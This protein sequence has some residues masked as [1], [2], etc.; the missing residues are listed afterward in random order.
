MEYLFAMRSKPKQCKWGSIAFLLSLFLVPANTSIAAPGDL[1]LEIIATNEDANIGPDFNSITQFIVSP[2]ADIAPVAIDDSGFISFSADVETADGFERGFFQ[3]FAPGVFSTIL[4]TDQL[5]PGMTQADQSEP[6][7]FRFLELDQGRGFAVSP[8]GQSHAITVFTR[9]DGPFLY[10]ADGGTVDDTPTT[11]P[12]LLSPTRNFWEAVDISDGRGTTKM[13]S[14]GT[15]SNMLVSDTGAI[16]WQRGSAILR[17]FLPG[18]ISAVMFLDTPAPGFDESENA[19]LGAP[20]NFIGIDGSENAVFFCK[21]NKASGNENA[22]YRQNSSD[23]S[24]TLL[25]VEGVDSLPGGPGLEGLSAQ[26]QEEDIWV[27]Q[28]GAIYLRGRVS[29][30]LGGFW[31]ITIDAEGTMATELLGLFSSNGFSPAVTDLGEVDFRNIHL[32]DW[33]VSE[34]GTVF[35]SADVAGSEGEATSAMEGV[36]MIDPTDLSVKTVAR[37]G[38]NADPGSTDATYKIFSDITAAG[39]DKVAFIAELSDGNRGLFATDINGGVIKIALEGSP[40]ISCEDPEDTELEC[41]VIDSIHFTPDHAGEDLVISKGSPGLNKFGELAFLAT[42]ENGK[43]ALVRAKFE[44][45]ERPIGTTFIWDGGAGTNDWHTITDGRSN[46]TDIA[47]TPWNK[48]PGTQGNE[49]VFV[50]TGA[51][52]ELR[53][54]VSIRELTLDVSVLSLFAD[55]EFSHFLNGAGGSVLDL[56]LGKIVSTGG[57]FI[58]SGS[59]IKKGTDA[60][61]VEVDDFELTGGSVTVK[62]GTLNFK[63]TISNF[64]DSA[65]LVEDGLF[66]FDENVTA[67]RGDGTT[68]TVKMGTLDLDVFALSFEDNV[69]LVAE[70]SG[71]MI[72]IGR[73][74]MVE[75]ASIKLRSGGSTSARTFTLSGGGSFELRKD[76]DLI[77]GDR[78]INNHSGIEGTGLIIDID[79]DDALTVP[80]EVSFINQGRLVLKDGGLTYGSQPNES[81]KILNR[82]ILLV[83]SEGSIIRFDCSSEAGG[84]MIL[85]G[86]AAFGS[87]EFS[88]ITKLRTVGGTLVPLDGNS[89]S[90]FDKDS[91]IIGESGESLIVL[92][93]QEEANFNGEVE[94]RDGA[95]VEISQSIN[96]LSTSATVGKDAELIY[97]KIS[98]GDHTVS[99]QGKVLFKGDVSPILTGSK[100]TLSTARARFEN[101]VLKSEGATIYAFDGYSDGNSTQDSTVEFSNVDTDKNAFIEVKDRALLIVEEPLILRSGLF[102]D[103]DLELAASIMNGTTEEGLIRLG[104]S[105]Q[106]DA[107]DEADFASLTITSNLAEPVVVSPVFEVSS[108]NA[109][110]KVGQS[111]RV[112]FGRTTDELIEGSVL[113]QGTWIVEDFA[114]CKIGFGFLSNIFPRVVVSIGKPHATLPSFQDLPKPNDSLTVNGVL[115]LNDAILDMDGKTLRFSTRIVKN[116]TSKIIGSVE[117]VRDAVQGTPTLAGNI[118]IEGDL[119]LDGN[120]SL[121]AS[122]GTGLITGD[123]TLFPGSDVQFEFEGTEPGIG[124][125]FLEVGGTANLDGKLSLSLIDE[126]LPD[127]G[128]SFLFLKAGS[129]AGSFA[130]I[131]QDLMGR[132]RRFDV[133]SEAEGLTATAKV[134]LI[135]S[136]ED[137]RA[138][139]FSETEAQDDL[140]SGLDADPDFDG[141]VNLEEYISN[142]LPKVSSP[143]F[144]EGDFGKNPFKIR[145]ANR[146]TDYVWQLESSS[147]LED[148]SV[149]E[150]V[151]SEISL[152]Q[153]EAYFDLDLQNPPVEGDQF[154]RIGIQEAQP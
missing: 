142:G 12:A 113:K 106:N 32:A 56:N 94:V 116:G 43:T 53:S 122:P 51:N 6:G 126:Y 124:F 28:N 109:I 136:Y 25:F 144:F 44:G 110:V 29:T 21:V 90:H 76:V 135:G 74:E 146:V 38:Q 27:S 50:T 78:F 45:E 83:P 152:D 105:G 67:F 5:A 102:V 82:G 86:Y 22:V 79:G 99:G 58:F 68:V 81:G 139:Y 91:A 149:E 41:Q 30:S 39:E 84:N 69:S 125:D 103:G 96:G 104:N 54:S 127:G 35:F 98:F 64:V 115:V 61:T 31:R 57:D 147:N 88:E 128:E 123:L 129:L 42:F 154:Y 24:L 151:L 72:K 145:L 16:F 4:Q 62:A 137:W 3:A 7:G 131:D 33:A 46:W 107:V 2:S 108:S 134:I 14:G 118:N 26:V 111:S 48:A 17:S 97:D 10:G 19:M 101:A 117:S 37:F 66:K 65:L 9:F 47:G 133:A 141:M 59:I 153:D 140:I 148:W 87:I 36:W 71:A 40:L 15:G 1:Q 92:K 85:G 23:N 49:K 8:D 75:S 70:A 13:E 80:N 34:N 73:A 143:L 20:F 112:E 138:I 18:N 114:S 93:N 55:L 121:G 77:A 120:L 60:F 89:S 63:N 119:S 11:W 52:V 150:I 132:Q 130:E 95:S 100:L